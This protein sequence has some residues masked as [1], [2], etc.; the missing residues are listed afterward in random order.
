MQRVI[1]NLCDNTADLRV[2]TDLTPFLASMQPPGISLINF[3]AQH[4]LTP[5]RFPPHRLCSSQ[6]YFCSTTPQFFLSFYLFDIENDHHEQQSS[7]A[8]QVVPH[9]ERHEAYPLDASP[10]ER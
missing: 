6:T 9:G 3:L 1:L 8:R 5:H 7:Q 10:L 2:S 4:G